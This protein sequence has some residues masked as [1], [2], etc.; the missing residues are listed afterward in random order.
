MSYDNMIWVQVYDNTFLLAKL[1]VKTKTIQI[2]GYCQLTNNLCGLKFPLNVGIL[3]LSPVTLLPP[4]S[5]DLVPLTPWQVWIRN[6]CQFNIFAITPITVWQAMNVSNNSSN[7]F[8]QA[9]ARNPLWFQRLGAN[10]WYWGVFAI[11]SAFIKAESNY[12]S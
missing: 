6:S 7:T 9:G 10:E 4:N 1:R 11:V 2:F 8:R 12:T 3:N 5:K